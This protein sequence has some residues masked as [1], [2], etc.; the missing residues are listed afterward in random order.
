[1]CKTSKPT[2]PRIITKCLDLSDTVVEL[3]RKLS[4]TYLQLPTACTVKL[5]TQ[6]S[7]FPVNEALRDYGRR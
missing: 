4:Q 5:T 6:I 7:G 2:P 1:M 3:S